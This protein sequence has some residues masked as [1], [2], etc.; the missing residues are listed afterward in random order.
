MHNKMIVV[1]QISNRRQLM[2]IIRHD[3]HITTKLQA[4]AEFQ[5]LQKTRDWNKTIDLLDYFT[6][7]EGNSYMVTKVPNLTLSRHIADK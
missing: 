1:H 2:K 3:D 5:A 4:E 7:A 6:D